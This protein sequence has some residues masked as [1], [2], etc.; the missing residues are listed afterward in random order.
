[1]NV[2]IPDSKVQEAH[3]GPW[4]WLSGISCV[5]DTTTEGKPRPDITDNFEFLQLHNSLSKSVAAGNKSY[6]YSGMSRNMSHRIYYFVILIH[7][8]VLMFIT[9]FVIH[10]RSH[11]FVWNIAFYADVCTAI[12]G[13]NVFRLMNIKVSVQLKSRYVDKD[14]D[15]LRSNSALAAIEKCGLQDT[16]RRKTCFLLWL[17]Y[18]YCH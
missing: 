11:S 7:A 5:A 18:C 8:G 4:T 1:M 3:L 16:T 17:R 13:K 12:V 2:D 6:S 10:G 14:N 9:L 15:M